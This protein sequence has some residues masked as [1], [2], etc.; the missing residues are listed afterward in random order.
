M[1]HSAN[2]RHRPL[3]CFRNPRSL[4]S[5][6][7]AYVYRREAG[8]ETS[9]DAERRRFPTLYMTEKIRDKAGLVFLNCPHFKHL[10]ESTGND[11]G[12]STSKLS[13]KYKDEMEDLSSKGHLRIKTLNKKSEE[14]E[15]DEKKLKAKRKNK[16]NDPSIKSV[17]EYLRKVIRYHEKKVLDMI[18]SI[19]PMLGPANSDSEDGDDETEN[20]R[21][22]EKRAR[23]KRELKVTQ[24]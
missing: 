9:F 5:G 3:F 1:V 8:A 17:R 12:G 24:Y 22:D 23:T 13:D 10:R 11:L 21:K 2:G 4:T 14:Y 19:Y 20:G 6:Q 7:S 16:K 15:K 18:P